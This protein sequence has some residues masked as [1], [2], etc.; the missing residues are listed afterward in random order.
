MGVQALALPTCSE[1]CSQVGTEVG[2]RTLPSPKAP[3]STIFQAQTR[4]L[5][6]SG[7]SVSPATTRSS[8]LA[9]QHC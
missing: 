2:I 3:F 6:Q 1:L 4:P 8:F 9:P 7:A 5:P